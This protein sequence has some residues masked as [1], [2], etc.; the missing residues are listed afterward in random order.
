MNAL[1]LLS[2]IFLIIFVGA[3]VYIIFFAGTFYATE[4]IREKGK[5]KK[6]RAEQDE[7]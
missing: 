6:N 3:I 1:T 7:Q 4:K 5:S 2:I